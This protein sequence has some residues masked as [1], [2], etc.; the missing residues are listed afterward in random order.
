MCLSVS[1]CYNVDNRPICL[2]PW[3]NWP[4]R[5]WLPVFCISSQVHELVKQLIQWSI[6]LLSPWGDEHFASR[7]RYMSWSTINQVEY[8]S[9]Y[10]VH[11]VVVVVMSTLHLVSGPWVGKQLIQCSIWVI[12][13]PWGGCQGKNQKRKDQGG[14]MLM[15]LLTFPFLFKFKSLQ[16]QLNQRVSILGNELYIANI[17]IATKANTFSVKNRLLS[18]NIS[19]EHKTIGGSFCSA[20]GSIFIQLNPRIR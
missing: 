4:S 17:T 8:L 14:L 16:D 13:S 11:V 3:Q 18:Y 2:W 7:L 19:H 1:T 12:L 10:W 15:V 5:C 9:K 20:H 6:R